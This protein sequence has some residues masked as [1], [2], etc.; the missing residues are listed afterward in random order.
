[1]P[2]SIGLETFLAHLADGSLDGGRRNDGLA[3]R[4]LTEAELGNVHLEEFGAIR[5][6]NLTLRYRPVESFGGGVM[7]FVPN[8]GYRS[9]SFPQVS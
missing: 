6:G 1:M 2:L 8:F 3:A 9:R 7:F 4:I 5:F